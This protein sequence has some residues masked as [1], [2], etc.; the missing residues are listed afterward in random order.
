MLNDDKSTL[1][2][3]VQNSH[4]VFCYFYVSP[5]TIKNFEDRY[6]ENSWKNSKPM[7]KVFEVVN[8]E[9]RE[10]RTIYIDNLANNWFINLNE[11]GIDIFVKLGRMLPNDNFVA[12]AVSNTVTTPR[13]QQSNDRAVYY[14]DVSQN[15]I[16]KEHNL[17][18]SEDSRND[19][20]IHKEPKPYPF[21]EEKKN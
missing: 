5:M 16:K 6:G 11:D 7:I 14:V 9:A 2:L 18:T 8:G 12:F 21:L 13:S 17:P 4:N 1:T 10:I 3:L 19:S 15:F 20:N